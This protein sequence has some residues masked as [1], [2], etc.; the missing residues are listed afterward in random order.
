MQVTAAMRSKLND[1]VA[2]TPY[3]STVD[4]IAT[5]LTSIPL[6]SDSMNLGDYPGNHTS[7]DIPY[8]IVNGQ[9]EL[10]MFD[11]WRAT[12]NRKD[13]K[14]SAWVANRVFEL[15]GLEAP[16]DFSY[17]E[18]ADKDTTIARLDTRLTASN[19]VIIEI[20]RKLQAALRAAGKDSYY[21]VVM[22]SPAAEYEDLVVNV[23]KE[24]SAKSS[25][26]LLDLGKWDESRVGNDAQYCITNGKLMARGS[27]NNDWHETFCK[28]NE[29]L[30]K[31]VARR[32]LQICGLRGLSETEPAPKQP[33][34][35]E[36][37]AAVDCL[38]KDKWD[39]NERETAK[40]VVKRYR[41][42][43]GM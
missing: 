28:T 6:R 2:N 7:D 29:D 9:V 30:S 34:Q 18:L 16:Q 8:R 25:S 15:C 31:W 40:D 41:D 33:T 5:Y 23:I 20:R 27:W 38:C 21:K 4:V 24:L 19:K 3:V 1:I 26:A 22:S 12:S 42:Y 13:P 43:H 36:Y 35:R 14:F 10:F 11:S 32:V 39:V 37:D 17:Q